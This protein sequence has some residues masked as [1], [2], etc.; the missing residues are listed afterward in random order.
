MLAKEK[1]I[2]IINDYLNLFKDNSKL[3]FDS[4]PA[5][6][7]EIRKQALHNFE[8]TG[9]PSKTLENYKYTNLEPYFKNTYSKHF[10]PRKIDFDINDIFRCDV[11][12]LQTEVIIL[13]NGFYYDKKHPLVSLGDGAVVGS[14]AEGAKEYPEVF[15][16]HYAKYACTENEGLVALN[17]AF[18]Q[19]GL[20][21]YVPDNVI[22][23]KPIQ[24]IN[25]MMSDENIMAQYRNLIVIG[26]KAQATVIV[27]DHTL[28]AHKFLSNSVTEIVTG[29]GGNAKYYK[30]QNENND[31]T[32][33]S[34][35]FIH[36]L[37]DSTLDMSTISLHGGLIRNNVY[38]AL[39]EPGCDSSISGLFLSDKGQHVDS[40]TYIDHKA[41]NCT[42]NQLFK[43][44]LDD[45]ATG[46]FT[47]KIMVQP[48]AQKTL[49]YQ[50]N[51]NILLSNDVKMNSKPQLEIYADDV[52]CSHGAT[53]G[54][55]NDDAL[56]YIRSRGVTQKEA[57]LLLMHAFA[58]EVVNHLAV[59]P[60]RERIN[61][62][63]E[64]RLRGELSRC[65]NCPVHCC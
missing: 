31:A 61:S 2:E 3:I 18:A 44:V 37:K 40:Y 34:N 39:N 64:K 1:N 52:K 49:A 55:L 54:Q 22:I 32:Q 47:G 41:P 26:E 13:L 36:Q 51:N 19:D 17:T 8:D 57:R 11:P 4:T 24:V 35:T 23:E 59:E 10:A 53:S 16:K 25:I 6:I 28:S 5:F 20:F 42:S 45:Y 46:A 65:N 38:V 50:K 29:T 43:G 56:F 33:I 63:V 21:V 58:K 60:L 48:D 12:D 15:K 27:C 62:L 9:I 14:F 30:L 7:N